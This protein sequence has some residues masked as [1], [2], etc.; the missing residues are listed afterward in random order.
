MEVK[1]GV[2]ISIALG[3]LIYIWSRFMKQ[4]L[5]MFLII[6]LLKQI[7][8]PTEKRINW[9]HNST[10]ENKH[11]IVF[12]T[13]K[14]FQANTGPVNVLEYT[15]GNGVN[16]VSVQKESLPDCYMLW[17]LCEPSPFSLLR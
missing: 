9:E 3:L 15:F 17:V 5:V 11:Q 12:C 2:K 10:R 7:E 6:E 16:I 8:W 1:E 14:P 13:T 4:K